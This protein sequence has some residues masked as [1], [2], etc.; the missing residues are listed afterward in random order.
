MNVVDRSNP[1]EVISLSQLH[2]FGECVGILL[3]ASL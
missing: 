3:E 2:E 1:K